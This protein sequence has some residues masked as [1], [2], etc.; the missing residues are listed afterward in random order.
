[1]FEN[2]EPDKCWKLSTGTTVEAKM[3]EYAIGCNYEHP[4]HSLVMDT[5]D[6]TWCDIFTSE[7]L[8]EIKSYKRK[9][10][11][12]LPVPLKTYMNSLK[13]SEDATSL[14]TKLIAE[15]ELPACE[16]VRKYPLG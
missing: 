12:D 15:Q 16:W 9:P 3:K 4:G 6:K 14:K 11:N 13:T 7:E 1:M 2:L 8:L 5:S 10:L